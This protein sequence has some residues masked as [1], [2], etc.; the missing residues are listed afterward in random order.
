MLK[1]DSAS[2]K[3]DLVKRTLITPHL[4]R[5]ERCSSY[6]SSEITSCLDICTSECNGNTKAQQA[7]FALRSSRTPSEFRPSMR[8]VIWSRHVLNT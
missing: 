3:L 7:S 5:K 1:H 4:G 8:A 2:G 6:S